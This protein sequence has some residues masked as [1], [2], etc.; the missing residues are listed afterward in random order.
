ME[1][2]ITTDFKDD[3]KMRR[4]PLLSIKESFFKELEFNKVYYMVINNEITAFKFIGYS[5]T[6]EKYCIQTP[7]GIH[8]HLLNCNLFESV[9]HYYDY[10]SGIGSPIKFETKGIDFLKINYK[11]KQMFKGRRVFD[12][13]YYDVEYLSFRWD[14]QKN[15][16]CPTQT[17]IDA[18]FY[19]EQGLIININKDKSDFLNYADCVKNNLENMKIV[20][21]GNDEMNIN[22]NIVVNTAPKKIVRT[23][24][25]IED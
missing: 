14:K 9:Q 6:T 1:T 24:T 20:D 2:F 22:I 11:G 8:W 10:V 3:L 7:N 13:F 21:F 16:P 23:I 15:K 19:C 5:F 4:E 25:I 18:C 12:N 17:Y